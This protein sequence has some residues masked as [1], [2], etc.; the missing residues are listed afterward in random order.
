MTIGNQLTV[1][2]K[3]D[4]NSDVHSLGLNLNRNLLALMNNNGVSLTVLSRNTGIAIPTIKRLQSDPTTNPTLTTLLPIANFFGV[5]V[6]QLVD[7]DFSADEFYGYT[8][9]KNNWLKVPIIDWEHAI[10]WPQEKKSHPNKKHV[11]VDID[12][13]NNPY[14]LVVQED[15]WIGIPKNSILI[16]NS[17]LKPANKDY[18]VVCKEKG[19]PTL[20]QMCV[21][22]DKTYLRSLTPGL[23]A[24]AF[25]DSLKTLGVLMQIRRNI[26]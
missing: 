15:D 22:G 21:E 11:L 25:D 19:H 5:S 10:S 18:V 1:N 7:K 9:N 14:A 24:A 3:V 20:K 26:K 13:G 23:P 12:A 17:A 16:I 2:N 6:N 4:K 8:E